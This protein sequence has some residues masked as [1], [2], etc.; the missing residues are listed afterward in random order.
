MAKSDR[1]RQKKTD[2]KKRRDRAHK[3]KQ[4]E[5]GKRNA[6]LD[7]FR[8]KAPTVKRFLKQRGCELK[9][10]DFLD[11]YIDAFHREA[12]NAAKESSSL[13]GVHEV[14][15]RQYYG[16]HDGTFAASLGYTGLTQVFV[17][18]TDVGDEY[19]AQDRKSNVNGVTVAFR[20][21]AGALKTIV[22]IRKT[23]P[24]VLA[25]EFKYAFK[26]MALFHELGHVEDWEKAI[27]LKD[28]D[29]AIL[30]AE[31]YAHQYALRRLMEGD[32]R[33][34]L[35]T[36][37][38]ALEELTKGDG[39]RKDV[40][41]RLAGSE[42]FVECRECVKTTWHDYLSPEDATTQDL[43]EAAASLSEFKRFA[44]DCGVSRPT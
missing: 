26:L 10:Y 22:M 19:L 12:G 31:V 40:A 37:L 30:E 20:N 32:Y 5:R 18:T 11:S 36:Y 33:Q 44:G 39:Y 34:A 15:D 3:V 7:D 41:T 16:S 24:N 8:R 21:T 2:A 35:S 1:E 13:L 42:L 38:S 29:V 23:V 4:A 27:N 6:T 25:T 43:H 28:G 9:F 14:E 17:K